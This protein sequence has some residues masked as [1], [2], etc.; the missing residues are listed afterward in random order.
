MSNTQDF[1][2]VSGMVV[3]CQMSEP[4]KSFVK[5]GAPK[6]PDEYK[7][8]LVLTDEDY[9]DSLE[10]YGKSLDT[11]LS[12]KKVKTAEFEN[13]YKTA[14]PEDAGKNVWVF[15]LRKSTE[16]GKT[17]K[18]VPMQYLPKVFEK[19]KNT[20]IDITHSKLVGNGSYGTLSIDKFDRSAGGSSLFLKN[21][22]VTDLIEYVKQ[23]S[24]YEA[25]SEFDDE[26]PQAKAKA[27]TPAKAPVKAKAAPPVSFDD[28]DDDIPFATNSPYFDQTTSKERK[29]ARYNF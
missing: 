3:Y 12:I 28:M 13:I 27:P 22:L 11:L 16:L 5:P 15:T 23:E 19:V 8:S 7:C 4:V 1:S 21:L 29:M 17:G 18:P 2:K 10:A 9:V 26:V 14:A 6:K 20:M 24:E 25:G